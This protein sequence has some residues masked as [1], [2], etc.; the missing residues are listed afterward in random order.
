MSFRILF[1]AFLRFQSIF[2][3]LY[4]LKLEKW[5]LCVYVSNSRINTGER[6][7]QYN[8][9]S[10][11]SGRWHGVCLVNVVKLTYSIWFL[12]RMQTIFTFP[13]IGFYIEKDN[14][15][16]ILYF[17]VARQSNTIHSSKSEYSMSFC[18][19]LNIKYSFNSLPYTYIVQELLILQ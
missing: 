5:F 14:V 6:E 2:G 4:L 8:Q 11:V 3:Q 15:L 12:I 19:P 9:E 18:L 13:T 17:D 1:N 16:S 10:N 7:I